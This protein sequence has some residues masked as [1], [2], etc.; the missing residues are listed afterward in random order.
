MLDA[1]IRKLKYLDEAVRVTSSR[2]ENMK[3]KAWAG[4]DS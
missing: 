4:G 1:L 2:L 3:M